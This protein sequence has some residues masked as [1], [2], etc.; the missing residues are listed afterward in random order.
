MGRRNRGKP[1]PD[2]VV[3]SWRNPAYNAGRGTRHRRSVRII[4]GLVPGNLTRA[5]EGEDVGTLIT[6]E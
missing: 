5:L 2:R 6:C 3:E 1:Q 4:N